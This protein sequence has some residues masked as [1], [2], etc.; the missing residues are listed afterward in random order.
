MSFKQEGSHH[1][2]PDTHL[3]KNFYVVTMLS[4]RCSK[5]SQS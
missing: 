1:R 2:V 4:N 3:L 5:R